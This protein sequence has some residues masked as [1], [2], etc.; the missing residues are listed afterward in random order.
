VAAAAPALCLP[1]RD[2]V[3]TACPAPYHALS[4]SCGKRCRF[5]PERHRGE[6]REAASA[7]FAAGK[8]KEAREALAEARALAGGRYGESEAQAAELAN[9]ISAQAERQAVAAF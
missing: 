9:S 1:A 4:V 8:L 7:L 5:S 6:V 3:A 2:L